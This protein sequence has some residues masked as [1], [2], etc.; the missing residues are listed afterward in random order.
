ML[1]HGNVEER[2]IDCWYYILCYNIMAKRETRQ[3][4]DP[5]AESTNPSFFIAVVD[6]DV[7]AEAEADGDFEAEAE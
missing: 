6:V 2:P 4:P 5:S 1:H 7:E 3:R